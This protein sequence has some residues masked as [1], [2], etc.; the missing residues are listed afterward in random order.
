M[1]TRIHLIVGSQMGNAEYVAEQIAEEFGAKSIKY[2]LHLSPELA[3]INRQKGVWLICTSTYGAGDY[4]DNLLNFVSEIEA[5]DLTGLAYGLIG[6]GDRS[7][8]TFNQA[9]AKLDLLLQEKGAKR[10]ADRLEIDVLEPELPED[11]ALEWLPG[12]LSAV[13]DEK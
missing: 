12:W 11:Q 7:Y 10:I 3:Q 6:I 4:P 8:D 1:E 5:S 13:N 2:E 9:A